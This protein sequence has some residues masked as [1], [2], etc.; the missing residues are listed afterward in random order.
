MNLISTPNNPDLN[1][2]ST[3]QRSDLDDCPESLQGWPNLLALSHFAGSLQVGLGLL[4][5]ACHSQGRN[6]S[7][8]GIQVSLGVGA[9]IQLLEG[10]QGLCT[11]AQPA[12]G[13]DQ[14]RVRDSIWTETCRQPIARSC[15][16]PH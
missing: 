13:C 3:K 15:F 2:G 12:L 14:G 9:G 11:V 4:H 16:L 5:P 10:L 6:D 1:T 7:I 8:E